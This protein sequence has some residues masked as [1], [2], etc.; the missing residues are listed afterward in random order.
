MVCAEERNAHY[1][2]IL[3]EMGA[4]VNDPKLMTRLKTKI[5]WDEPPEY[6]R[7]CMKVLIAAGA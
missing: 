2:K 3:I 5:G 6:A 1:M 7:E 4:N